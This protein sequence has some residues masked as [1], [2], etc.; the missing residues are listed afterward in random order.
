[1]REWKPGDV[2]LVDSWRGKGQ[3]AFRCQR[4]MGRPTWCVLDGNDTRGLVDDEVTLARRIIVIDP[5]D[6][7]QVGRLAQAIWDAPGNILEALDEAV[8]AA[9]RSLVEPEVEEPT[10]LGAVVEDA[11]G[12]DWHRTREGRWIAADGLRTRAGGWAQISRPLTLVS[13]GTKADESEVQP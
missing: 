8:Q 2:A 12:A 3:I 13:K 6:R 4:G 11:E 9:L 5:G 1:M 7:E 10:G